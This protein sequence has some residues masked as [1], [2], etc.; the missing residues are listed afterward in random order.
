VRKAV[1]REEMVRED[2]EAGDPECMLPHDE[3][4]RHYC[5][6]PSSATRLQVRA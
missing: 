4:A 6:G 1:M 2:D 3:H 5:R